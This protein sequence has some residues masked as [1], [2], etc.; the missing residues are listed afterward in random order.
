MTINQTKKNLSIET[1]RGIA[2][3]LVVLGHVIGS[4]SNNGLKVP[5]ESVW[6]W[7]Y[8]A[9]QYITMPL[10]TVISGFVYA[11]K[12]VSRFTSNS[13]FLWGKVNRLLIPLIVVSSLFFVLQYL[14]PGTN[15]KSGLD[16]IWKI[17][18]YPYAVFWFLQGIIIVFII[19]TVLENFRLLDNLKPAL[20]C[21]A[22][23]AFVFVVLP[24]KLN[25]F[26]LSRVPFLLTF[27][28]LGLL[29]KRFYD[30]MFK[31]SITILAAVIFLCA[32]SY[33]LYLFN[34]PASRQIV[35][36]LTLCV[37]SAASVLLIRLGFQSKKLTWLGHF[38]YAIYLFH[39]FGAVTA[40]IILGKLA[41]NNL[42]IQVMVE[43]AF[44][45]SFP[46]VLQ[47]LCGS[48]K[49]LAVLLFG[50]KIKTSA[51]GKPAYGFKSFGGA[52]S[53]RFFSN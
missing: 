35:N 28:L 33:Q 52:I 13:T 9:Q 43:L 37:G 10:F 48:N 24:F 20:V 8:Y 14:A 1:L 6:R 45:L 17:Y 21:F 41:V 34:T 25:Y 30:T 42:A 4:S 2:I 3:T 18:I 7:I 12:P 44:G 49:V 15:S 16:Q 40:R 50:D 23:A 38:S 51:S 29:L 22:I 5:D 47:L 26:S 11:Y 46:I 32:F 27:F 19:I 39:V 53:S 36:L 31:K